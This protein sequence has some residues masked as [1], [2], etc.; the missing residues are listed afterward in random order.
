MAITHDYIQSPHRLNGQDAGLSLALFCVPLA[1][2]VEPNEEPLCEPE[3]ASA[4]EL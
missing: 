2:Q 1:E 4:C 3:T